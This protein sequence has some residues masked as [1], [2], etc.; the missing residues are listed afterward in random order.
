LILYGKFTC[1]ICYFVPTL[2]F[3]KRSVLK[4]AIF[5]KNPDS[6]TKDAWLVPLNSAPKVSNAI[7]SN[8][9]VSTYGRERKRES[10]GVQNTR[11]LNKAQ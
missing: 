8:S 5:C 10:I 3:F 6:S 9:Y 2:W 1:S 7:I 4:M 11:N